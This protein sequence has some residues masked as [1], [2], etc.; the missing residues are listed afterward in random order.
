MGELESLTGA[1]KVNRM[2]AYHI[3]PAHAEHGDFFIRAST[4]HAFTTMNFAHRRT[5]G[6]HCICQALGR[7]TW[8]VMLLS[9]MELYDFSVKIA[10]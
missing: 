2:I 4:N 3:P 10:A 8:G 6:P 5:H 9:M 1:E 7:T